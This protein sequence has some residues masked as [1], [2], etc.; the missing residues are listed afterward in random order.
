MSEGRRMGKRYRAINDQI[1]WS[2]LPREFR[3]LIVTEVLLGMITA[4]FG[5]LGIWPLFAG[6]AFL[7]FLLPLWLIVAFCFTTMLYT[8][9]TGDQADD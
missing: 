2:E 7:S 5:F 4:I 6:A 3:S 1:T 9:P 8:M